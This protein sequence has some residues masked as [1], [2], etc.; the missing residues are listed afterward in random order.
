MTLVKQGTKIGNE[1]HL[2]LPA[3]MSSPQAHDT[4][5]SHIDRHT[6][7]APHK[8]T[9]T[10]HTHTLTRPH[11]TTHPQHFRQNPD[12][13]DSR[14]IDHLALHKLQT[15][16]QAKNMK[17]HNSQFRLCGKQHWLQSNMTAVCPRIFEFLTTLKFGA[18]REW[19]WPISCWANMFASCK[20]KLSG[21]GPLG[22]R[23]A[24]IRAGDG[25]VL[26]RSVMCLRCVCLCVLVCD[27]VCCLC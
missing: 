6:A 1:S 26:K 20:N 22:M 10:H 25:V 2:I 23:R 7:H 5:H 17:T 8:H 19:A 14:H 13:T 12:I 18:L 16:E 4:T 3:P 9:H 27:V 24:C 15:L 11:L 21:F